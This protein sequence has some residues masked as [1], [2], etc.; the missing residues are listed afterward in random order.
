MSVQLQDNRLL[1]FLALFT[2]LGTLLCCALPSLFVL[3]GLG[4]TVASVLSAAPWLISLSHH[5]GWAFAISGMLI[6]GNFFYV[7]R[8]APRLCGAVGEACPADG[9]AACITASRV[10][11]TALWISAATW[12]TGFFTAFVLGHLLESFG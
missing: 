12:V 3:L 2:S 11:R 1:G 7:Y 5:K 8:L 10:S 4:A 9:A 6:A